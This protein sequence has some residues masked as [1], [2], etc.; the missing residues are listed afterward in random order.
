MNRDNDAILKKN[1]IFAVYFY[2][3]LFVLGIVFFIT[4]VVV[5]FF[6]D[7]GGLGW[8][9]V[10]LGLVGGNLARFA[11]LRAEKEAREDGHIE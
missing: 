4:G 7:R 1:A 2:T 6:T 5:Y 9:L 8:L 3:A 10:F 11:A